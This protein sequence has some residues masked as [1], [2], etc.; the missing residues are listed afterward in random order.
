[1]VVVSLAIS[2]KGDMSH[3]PSPPLLGA[4]LLVNPK[5]KNFNVKTHAAILSCLAVPLGN[6]EHLCLQ[7]ILS[8]S[9]LGS[10]FGSPGRGSNFLLVAGVYEG[11]SPEKLCHTGPASLV[12]GFLTHPCLALH[13]RLTSVSDSQFR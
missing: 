13:C 12:Q 6:R 2:N 4:V 8:L 3:T 11:L 5:P 7:L 10:G 9:N 1:M